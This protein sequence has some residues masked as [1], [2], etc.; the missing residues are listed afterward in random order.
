MDE[1]STT[2]DA[3]VETPVVEA[4]A[5]AA[6]PTTPDEPT[7]EPEASVE[8]PATAPEQP[9]ESEDEAED[10]FPQFETPQIPQLDFNNLPAGE[11]GLIDPSVLASHIN[12][13]LAQTQQS[14]YT[15]AQQAL[16][17]QRAEEKAW[18]KAFEKHP[19]LKGNKVLRDMVHQARLGDFTDKLSRAKDATQVKLQTPTQIA[20]KLFQE[21]NA[22]K[23]EGMKQATEN[24]TVQASAHVETSSRTSDDSA[25]ARNEAFKNINNPNKEVAQQARTDLLK[26][27][28]FG[29]Q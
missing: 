12:Q 17:E 19:E 4:P 21:F 18:D 16:Q 6:E 22:K 11:D 5:P 14:A 24:V 9:A 29:D 26:R 8:A 3:P 20:D 2:T 15:A 23:A 7:T 27:Y 28:L 10:E 13:A 25:T 1:Q